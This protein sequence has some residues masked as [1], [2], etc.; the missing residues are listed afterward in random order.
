MA[1]TNMILGLIIRPPDNDMSE[2]LAKRWCAFVSTLNRLARPCNGRPSNVYQRFGHVW[3]Y[4]KVQ[5]HFYRRQKV[6]STSLNFEPPSF[7]N[8]V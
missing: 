1:L 4:F 6:R 5:R 7:R 2:G 8:G 3:K